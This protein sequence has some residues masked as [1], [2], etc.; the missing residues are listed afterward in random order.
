MVEYIFQKRIFQYDS[1]VKSNPIKSCKRIFRLK[2]PVF[3]RI[4]LQIQ[5]TEE[6][7]YND[8]NHFYNWFLRELHDGV[9]CLWRGFRTVAT[10]WPIVHP[11]GDIW[12]WRAMVMMMPTGDTPDSSTRVLWQSY[13]QRHQGKAGGM[14]DGVRILPISIWDTSK[15]L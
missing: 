14:D 5:V 9:D 15:D 7:D 10:N 11:P 1:Y 6:N 12:A 4:K 13:Q 8:W 2:C 3:G